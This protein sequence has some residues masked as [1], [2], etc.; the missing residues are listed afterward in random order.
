MTTEFVAVRHGETD[1]NLSA[2]LQ[3]QLDT[4]LNSLGL[5]QAECVAE[6]L[7][8]EKFDRIFSS[9]LS[10]A[11]VTAQ[12]IAKYHEGVPLVPLRVL[13]EWDLG[14]LQGGKWS[15][16]RLHYP[17]VAAA[18]NA[19]DD[20]AKIPGGESRADLQQRI[21]DCLDELADRYEG[22]RILLVSHGGSI[23]AMFRHVV[24]PLPSE[25][26]RQP[27]SGNTGV[28]SFRRID[29]FWQLMSWND[30][31]HLARIGESESVTY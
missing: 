5:R 26:T 10:R 29:G 19:G 28:S 20:Q 6:R 11:L 31:S 27:L 15:D 4:K 2:T 25:Y 18:I 23:K 12:T 30:T 14:V 13:R 7:R 21:D 1:E 16:L 17:D 8:H 22:Q 24:G 3:G 9:D